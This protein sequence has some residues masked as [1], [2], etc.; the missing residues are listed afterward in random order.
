MC[1]RTFT[2]FTFLSSKIYSFC[3]TFRML[4]AFLDKITVFKSFFLLSIKLSTYF[5]ISGWSNLRQKD[6]GWLFSLKT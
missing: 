1:K 3:E 5:P 2:K 4:L 6:D